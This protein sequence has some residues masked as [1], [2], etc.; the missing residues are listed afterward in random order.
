MKL[1]LGGGNVVI[2]GFEN[3]DRNN[4]KEVYPLAVEDNTVDEIRASHILE[5]F[6]YNEA[7]KVLKHWWTKL[8]PGGTIKIAVPDLE[9][10]IAMYQDK[11]APNRGKLLQ[12]IHGGQ[13]DSNDIH[14]CSF[15]K[16]TLVEMMT[17]AG[18]ADVEEWHDD[19]IDCAKLPISLN[20][21]GTKVETAKVTATIGAVMSMPRLAFTDNMHCAMKA[22]FPLHI[23]LFRGSGV[24]WGQVLTRMILELIEKEDPDWILTIDYDTWFTKQHILGLGQI[25]AENP[26][27]DAVVP[28][29]VIRQ[30]VTP[31]VGLRNEDGSVK[32]E[33]KISEFE[34]DVTKIGTGHFGLTLF[35]AS[36]FKKMTH[37]WLVGVPNKE[38]KWG[39]GRLDED[40]Y[41]WNK[42]EAEGFNAVLANKIPI[43]HLQM[44]CTWPGKMEDNWK[45]I[46]C[47]TPDVESGKYPEHCKL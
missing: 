35:R 17:K 4:G 31:L 33:A 38:G 43:G 12:Y 14:K 46:H 21:T 15:D 44:M 16:G 42:F 2:E 18:F 8:K 28:L 30:G 5:H 27:V 23:S 11:E 1:N 41:F 34:G 26:D 10:L 13:L 24:F 39:D 7:F 6:S 37:P 9:K 32:T 19:I 45:P 29:Q 20:L 25:L 3:V 40:I 36:V 22:L 47:F